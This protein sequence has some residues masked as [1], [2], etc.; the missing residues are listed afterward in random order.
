MLRLSLWGAFIRFG[1]N[2]GVSGG[3]CLRKNE[4]FLNFVMILY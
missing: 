2:R 3:R 1:V 4:L